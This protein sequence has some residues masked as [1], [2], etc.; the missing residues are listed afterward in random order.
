LK[1]FVVSIDYRDYI[2]SS[3]KNLFLYLYSYNLVS[4]VTLHNREL[5]GWRPPGSDSY[6]NPKPGEI[7]VFEDFFKRVFGVPVHLFLQGL[8]LYYVIGICNLHPNSILLVLGFIHLCEAYGEIQSHFDLFLYLF[9]LRKKGS[10][11]GSKIASGA[12]LTL[13][14]GMKQEYLNCP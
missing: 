7:V 1:S 9:C 14:D 6:P 13:R 12:Y 2:G 10:Q 3:S 8:C 4:F 11:G 5:A